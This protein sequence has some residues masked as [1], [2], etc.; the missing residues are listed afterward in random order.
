[1]SCARQDCAKKKRRKY[2]Y[3]HPVKTHYFIIL[4]K[5]T[6][7]YMTETQ[8]SVFLWTILAGV[9]TG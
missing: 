9:C 6:E 3:Y 4:P 8:I 2:L 5:L 7:D 1:M